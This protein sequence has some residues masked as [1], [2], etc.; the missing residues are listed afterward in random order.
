MWIF[1]NYETFRGLV[2]CNWELKKLTRMTTYISKELL[3]KKERDKKN[4]WTK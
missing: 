2:I 4:K 3:G 1:K